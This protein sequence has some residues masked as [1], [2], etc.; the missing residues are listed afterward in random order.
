M[1]KLQ[2]K[3]QQLEDRLEQGIY[4]NKMKL[5][6]IID[7]LKNDQG[8]AQTRDSQSPQP[9]PSSLTSRE[10]KT[11]TVTSTK[12]S[13]QAPR[14]L[15]QESS[16]VDSAKEDVKDFVVNEAHDLGAAA[17][18][19]GVGMLIKLASKVPVIGPFADLLG[20]VMTVLQNFKA[21]RDA[22]QS[23]QKRLQHIAN[24]L[25]ELVQQAVKTNS[26]LLDYYVKQ[27]QDILLESKGYF[28]RFTK[29]G[30]LRTLLMGKSH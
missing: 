21:N 29:S 13:I 16:M 12:V 25:A 4:A 17:A 1:E 18:V 7:L 23:F 15:D 28:Q 14:D 24:V 19:A 5:D 2:D 3:L 8:I 6:I 9:M 22:A 27:M 20:D 26:S 30:F 11:L 10:G